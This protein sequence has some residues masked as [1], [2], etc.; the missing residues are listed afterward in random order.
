MQGLADRTQYILV[1]LVVLVKVLAYLGTRL[2]PE[3]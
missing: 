1:V 2:S 3:T